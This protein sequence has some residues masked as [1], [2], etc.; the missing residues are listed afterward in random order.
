MSEPGGVTIVFLSKPKFVLVRLVELQRFVCA[1][2]IPVAT[3]KQ[4][5]AARTVHPRMFRQRAADVGQI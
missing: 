2:N 1:S 5:P 3:S 4:N